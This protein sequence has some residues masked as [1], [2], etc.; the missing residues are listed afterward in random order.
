LIGGETFWD[1]AEDAIRQSTAKFLYVLSRTSNSKDGVLRELQLAQAL[2]KSQSL[3]NFIVPLRIDDLRFEDTTIELQRILSIQFHPS[4]ANG[5]AQ[6]LRRLET[7]A[8]PRSRSPDPRQSLPGGR[9]I[10]ALRRESS[11]NL[12]SICPTTSRSPPGPKSCS[13]MSSTETPSGRSKYRLT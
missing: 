4:W 2:A 5:L 1:N 3:Q 7:D 9:R 10:A 11:T 12:T 6:L 13:F 8:V